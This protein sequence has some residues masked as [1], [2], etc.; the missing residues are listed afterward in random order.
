ME[1]RR[2]GIDRRSAIGLTAGSCLIVCL[3]GLAAPGGASAAEPSGV[4]AAVVT[5]GQQP[6]SSQRLVWS[7]FH[8]DDEA[9]GLMTADVDGRHER[10]LTHPPSGVSDTEPVRSP[11]GRRV[12]FNR[13][14]A[15]GVQIVIARVDGKGGVTVVDTGCREPCADDINPGWTPDGRHL[16]FTRV[17]GPF[18]P[19]TNDAASA[20][21]YTTRLDGTHLRRLSERG[22]DGSAEDVHARF[23]P[24]GKYLV[25]VR[26]QRISGIVR[27]AIFRMTPAGTR[28]QQLTPWELN[29]DRASVSPARKGPTAGLVAFETHGGPEPTQGD[30]ATLPGACRSLASCTAGIRLVTANTGTDKSSFAA[31]W[32]PNGQR[33]AYAEAGPS[34]LDIWTARYDGRHASQVTRSPLPDFSPAWSF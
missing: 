18:D 11:D 25:F 34:G 9:I 16:T 2:H 33:L 8:P 32:S 10:E 27:V 20:L 14:S 5:G 31:S 29:A 6:S 26:V 13:E 24:D 1:S 28:V 17:V 12:V 21:L 23:A 30:I 22:N 19:V 7:R 4:A 15:D 3:L